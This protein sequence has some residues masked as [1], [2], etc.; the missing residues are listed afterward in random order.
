MLSLLTESIV[1]IIL[2]DKGTIIK[3]I[4][5]IP[6]KISHDA[7]IVFYKQVNLYFLL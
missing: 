4:L 2:L 3:K 5:G 6:V 1:Q 7:T